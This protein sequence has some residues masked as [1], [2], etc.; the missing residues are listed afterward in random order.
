[1]LDKIREVAMEKFA[2]EAE[3]DAFMEGFQKEAATSL[4]GGGTLSGY[5]SSFLNNETVQRAGIGLGASL[6]GAGIVKAIS[7]GSHAVTDS[8]LRSRFEMALNQVISTNRA[9]KGVKPEK[10]QEYA[11]TIFKF[12]PHVASDPNILGYLLANAVQGESIDI[13]TVKMLVDLEGRYVDNHRTG[14]LVGIST[15]AA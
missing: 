10:V 15:K 8:N 13:N 5:A 14:S 1:M 2:T 12:A 4:F 11:A 6:L 9:L 3:V 7:M